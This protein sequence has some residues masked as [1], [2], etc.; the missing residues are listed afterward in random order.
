MITSKNKDQSSKQVNKRK[1]F[2][3]EPRPDLFS[4]PDEYYNTD[5][6]LVNRTRTL[7]ISNMES[8]R[9]PNQMQGET[10][11]RNR[12]LSHGEHPSS[13]DVTQSSYLQQLT[14]KYRRAF[15]YPSQIPRQR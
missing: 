14:I 8:R 13:N 12:R 2:T 3:T 6:K 4:T 5:D 10:V 15:E 7:S 1:S 11:S 9:R